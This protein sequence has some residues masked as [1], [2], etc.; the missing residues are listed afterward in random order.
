MACGLSVARLG[1]CI[2]GSGLDLSLLSIAYSYVISRGSPD[3]SSLSMDHGCIVILVLVLTSF[4]DELEVE[5]LSLVTE[6]S[7]AQIRKYI[8]LIKRNGVS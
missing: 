4:T 7:P 3:L 5:S 8:Y 6:Y 1:S 2:C